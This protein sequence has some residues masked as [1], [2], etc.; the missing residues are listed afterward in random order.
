MYTL[1]FRQPLEGFP[2]RFDPMDPSFFHARQ[3][4]GLRNYPIYFTHWVKY[5]GRIFKPS[6]SER[7]CENH[8]PFRKK[9]HALRSYIA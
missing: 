6:A 2:V 1:F 5:I 7:A 3:G 9:N 8:I 4:G